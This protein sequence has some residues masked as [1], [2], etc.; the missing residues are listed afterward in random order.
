MASNDVVIL[1]IPNIQCPSCGCTFETSKNRFDK[2]TKA[3]R[4]RMTQP[5]VGGSYT[6][7]R[8]YSQD[9]FP[10]GEDEPS[11]MPEKNYV[12]VSCSNFHCNQYNKFKVLELPRIVTP[13]VK[14][15]LE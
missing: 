13:S 5:A 4:K 14:V 15:G 11:D 10:N 2:F 9:P 8:G 7:S 6:D 1:G 12:V 3:Q